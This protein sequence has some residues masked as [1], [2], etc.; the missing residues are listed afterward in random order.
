MVFF[1]RAS[2]CSSRRV[3]VA[4]SQNASCRSLNLVFNV[5]YNNCVN[6]VIKGCW[7]NVIRIYS[8][9]IFS[10]I[11]VIRLKQIQQQLKLMSGSNSKL[12][13]STWESICLHA[14]IES[15]GILS[16]LVTFETVLFDII[17]IC[18]RTTLFDTYWRYA[19]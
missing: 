10:Y 12:S 7:A 17:K 14:C 4:L 11:Q 9:D 16:R 1:G 15:K 6:H 5:Q 8:L 18:R 3:S 13:Y 19:G 2:N